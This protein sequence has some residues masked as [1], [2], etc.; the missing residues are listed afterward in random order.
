MREY[1]DFDA[2]R[3][4]R[5]DI[6]RVD[7]TR[8]AKRYRAEGGVGLGV[9]VVGWLSRLSQE[10]VNRVVVGVDRR[11]IDFDLSRVLRELS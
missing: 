8:L 2:L 11:R 5:G 10:D 4:T 1:Q 6:E 3:L 9:D 7:A